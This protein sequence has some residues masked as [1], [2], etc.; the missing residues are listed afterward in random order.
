M[1]V[2]GYLMS[3]IG[4]SIISEEDNHESTSSSSKSSPIAHNE[5]TPSATE[6]SADTSSRTAHS[7]SQDPPLVSLEPRGVVTETEGD[8]S[9]LDVPIM[10]PNGDVI[11]PSLTFDVRQ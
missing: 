1:P 6:S 5:A 9:L 8:I 2:F 3:C 7:Q 10:T 4:H 11:V